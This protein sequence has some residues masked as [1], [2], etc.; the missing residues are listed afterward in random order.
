MQDSHATPPADSP[1]PT[2]D[3]APPTLRQ[4]VARHLRT[5]DLRAAAQLAGAATLAVQQITE[6]VHQAVLG[7]LGQPEGRATG[8]TAGLT[9]LI[10][11]GVQGL[12]KLIADGTHLG[13]LKLQPWLDQFDS[14]RPSTP[15]REA[16]LAVLN[17]VMG[18]QLHASGNPLSIA[19]T[20]LWQGEALKADAQ[21]SVPGAGG[22]LVLLV[23]GL[24]V[25]ESIWDPKAS[26]DLAPTDAAAVTSAPLKGEALNLGDCLK[27]QAGYSPLYLRYN[28]GRHISENGR[29]L[30]LQLEQLQQRWP[31]AIESLSLIGYSMG[32]LVIR[33]ALAHAQAQGMAWPRWLKHMVFLATP[34]HGSPL[35]R[36]GNWL[37]LILGSTPYSAPWA[38]LARL[39]SA[40]ITDLRYGLLSDEDWT[41]KDRF[42]RS[43]DR[44]RIVPLPESVAC[45]A[46]AACAAT[47]RSRLAE[48]LT[49][50]GLVPLNSALGKHDD[51]AYTL[52]F[53]KSAL[54][55]VYR[56]HHLA[57]PTDPQVVQQVLQWLQS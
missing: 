57:V 43:P 19:M 11:Q 52:N 25:N 18:D 21:A 45:Y 36:A 30:A 33:S 22:K 12:T 6:G 10:Y 8:R 26:A 13:L 53:A 55:T 51:P 3:P 4:S 14:A 41:G 23:H 34:H 15:Q 42:R 39:R 5:S 46:I 7:T 31:H 40:G 28:T 1:S 29:E 27:K 49:G 37:D 48:R 2:P 16:A 50:D 54:H 32:G 9:G 35:E 20:I 38:Q 24:C 47:R 44:R 56:I 17:G